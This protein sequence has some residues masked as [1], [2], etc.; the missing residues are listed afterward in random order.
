MAKFREY[1]TFT[2]SERNGII[3]LLFLIILLII[4]I[5]VLPILINKEKVDYSSFENEVD[6]FISSIQYNDSSDVNKNESAFLLSDP[7]YFDFD[8]NSVAES[9]LKKM[10]I[11]AKVIKN[12]MNF[13]SKGG[14]FWDNEDV[15]KIWGLED[16]VFQKLLPYIKIK[17]LEKNKINKDEIA[18]VWSTISNNE[19]K[20]SYSDKT[21]NSVELNSADSAALC[22]LYGIGPGFSKRIM[23][24]RDLLG[25]FVSKDQLLEVFGFTPD[26]YSKIENL[27]Y[28][29]NLNVKKINLNKADYKQMIKHPYFTKEI[30]NKI[31]EY[32]RIQ[33]KIDNLQDL[34]K[35]KMMTQEQMDRIKAYIEL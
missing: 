18:K 2:R 22:S 20:K 11:S 4:S 5:Q 24:Y 9:E 26:M 35:D 15:K 17:A 6:N 33:L 7:E 34:V 1:F 32:R 30:V 8:P 21:D 31:I 27:V 28:V 29:D 10:G 14:K 12:W 19:Y 3:V 13:R 25:G 23:K 16:S